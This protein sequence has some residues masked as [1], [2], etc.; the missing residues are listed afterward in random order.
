[1]KIADKYKVII[2]EKYR[3]INEGTKGFKVQA[4]YHLSFFCLF[5][6]P[7]SEW[8]DFFCEE[9][10]LVINDLSPFIFKSSYH[11]KVA[12]EKHKADELKK[13]QDLEKA[14]YIEYLN[15]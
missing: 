1:M 12:V 14:H 9:Y 4:K 3:V 2:F 7:V 5:T 10:D 6:A 11:A 8:V 13:K 15:D